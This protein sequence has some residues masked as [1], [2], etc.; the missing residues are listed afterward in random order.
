MTKTKKN[1]PKPC[2]T[3]EY[4]ITINTY[5]APLQFYA[6][7][8]IFKRITRESLKQTS[9]WKPTRKSTIA[10]KKEYC[11]ICMCDILPKQHMQQL[12]CGH[13]FHKSCFLD[14]CKAKQN[15]MFAPSI[16]CPMC[17]EVQNMTY[18]Q[19]LKFASITRYVISN[20]DEIVI[21]RNLVPES[22]NYL[23]HLTG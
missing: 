7:K 2:Q 6:L 21:E 15:Y 10:Q 20:E 12:D 22:S 23:S 9:I 18:K 13:K 19:D 3:F 11:A 16:S 4:K 17:R 1:K 8:D 5:G 14:W